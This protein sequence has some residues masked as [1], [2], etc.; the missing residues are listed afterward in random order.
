MEQI[1]LIFGNVENDL[2]KTLL[3]FSTNV[4]KKFDEKITLAKKLPDI[5]STLVQKEL[6]IGKTELL[7]YFDYCYNL[8][9][10]LNILKKLI[11]VNGTELFL[12]ISKDAAVI[13]NDLAY[14]STKPSVLQIPCALK[15]VIKFDS[16]MK[17]LTPETRTWTEELFTAI[18]TGL[19][20]LQYCY[21]KPHIKLEEKLK[22]TEKKVFRCVAA[23]DDL[24]ND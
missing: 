6:E 24:G 3:E 10:E 15:V 5:C 9:A 20:D 1:G 21:F 17:K 7:A 13:A 2:N 19:T 22:E 12:E 23:N 18:T 4:Q 8:T 16:Y 11:V 14:C